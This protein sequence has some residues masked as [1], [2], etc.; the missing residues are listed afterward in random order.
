MRTGSCLLGLAVAAVLGG[1]AGEPF[2]VAREELAGRAGDAE[3]GTGE[4][5]RVGFAAARWPGIVAFDVDTGAVESHL[6][7]A[8]P[9]LDLAWHPRWR[10]LLVVQKHHELDA[11]RVLAVA[12]VPA[13]SMGVASPWVSGSARV[14]PLRGG[15]LVAAAEIGASWTM[16]DRGLE[17]VSASRLVVRPA[18]WWADETEPSDRV[19]ALNP[20][21]WFQGE[22]AIELVTATFDGGWVV[23]RFSHPMAFAPAA[24]MASG[25]PGEGWLVRAAAG[26]RTEIARFDAAAPSS[27]LV[28][29]STTASAAPGETLAALAFDEARALLVAAYESGRIGALPT[30]AGDAVD[31]T[32]DH[33]VEASEWATRS[34]AI[35]GARGAVYVATDGGVERLHLGGSP[36]RPTLERSTAF[37][38]GLLRGPIVVAVRDSR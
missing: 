26:G 34:V 8:G 12:A 6:P 27:A 4:P 38:G 14:L 17:P 28:F 9:V 22:A 11:S 2:S 5:A 30:E 25:R 36:S 1:C 15:V 19:V 3:P 24:R 23:E 7:L 20:H 37:D 18:S 29:A 32:L 33:R 13:L 16:L 31:L 21:A 35:D 10:R